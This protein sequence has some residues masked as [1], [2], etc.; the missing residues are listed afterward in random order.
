MR[1]L[2]AISMKR[3][4]SAIALPRA[5]KKREK[6]AGF[7]GSE[8]W[9][10]FVKLERVLRLQARAGHRAAVVELRSGLY[11]VAEVP[12]RSLRPEF[13]VL[14]VLAPLVIS[15]A[16]SALSNRPQRPRRP[17][18]PGPVASWADEEDLDQ[19]VEPGAGCSCR[20]RGEHG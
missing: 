11:L 12:E 10:P 13:G 20:K 15:A 17:E 9:G 3:F 6:R 8:R 16:R 2:R 19:A 4:R 7:A 18:L 5:E 1:L 14:P